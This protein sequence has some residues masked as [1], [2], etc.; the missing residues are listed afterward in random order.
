MCIP[1]PPSRHFTLACVSPSAPCR[2]SIQLRLVA[3]VGEAA[4]LHTASAMLAGRIL[5][6]R[7]GRSRGGRGLDVH[8]RGAGPTNDEL[9]LHMLKH[10]HLVDTPAGATCDSCAPLC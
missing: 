1:V 6:R 4:S 2:H 7:G 10:G 3:K 5:A 9:L 8:E